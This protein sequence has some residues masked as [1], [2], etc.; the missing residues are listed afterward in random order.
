M[1]QQIHRLFSFENL[2]IL[3]LCLAVGVQIIVIT[4]NN[5]SGYYVL[6]SVQ[7]FF[8]RLL[9]GTTLSLLFSFFLA[10]PDL[11]VIQY[12]NKTCPWGRKIV[13]RIVFQFFYSIILAVIVS[14]MFTLFAN[15]I[16]TYER[17]LS[18]VLLNN[19]LIFFSGK[20]FCNGNT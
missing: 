8:L 2:L 4:Y 9:R 14:F 20:Y 3:L 10:Y 11:F 12:L 13:Q 16:K 19:A 18:N 6:E 5:F 1:F 15:S 7:H 17:D